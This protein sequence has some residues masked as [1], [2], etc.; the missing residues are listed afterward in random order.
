MYHKFASYKESMT[1]ITEWRKIGIP[2]VIIGKPDLDIVFSDCITYDDYTL[3][4]VFEMNYTWKLKIRRGS[5]P[6]YVRNDL[7][8][9]HQLEPLDDDRYNI[10]Y[11]GFKITDE[12]RKDYENGVPMEKILKPYLDVMFGPEE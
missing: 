5:I 4:D 9:K 12:M 11:N 6:V 8:K 10:I 1:T 3:V 2:D 7:L